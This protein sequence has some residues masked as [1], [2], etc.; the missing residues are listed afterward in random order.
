MAPKVKSLSN[1]F[2]ARDPVTCARELIGCGF[3]WRG[4][5]GLVVET[6]AYA[7][8]EDEACHT[9]FK[10]SAR[11]FVADHSVGD[12]YIYLNYGVHWLVNVLTKSQDHGDGFVSLRALQPKWEMTTMRERRARVR[13]TDLC[14]GPG[15]LS[16]ALGLDKTQ[17]GMPIASCFEQGEGEVPI[18]IAGPRIGISRAKKRPWRFVFADNPHVSV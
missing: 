16:Q 2:F 9:F 12:S 11:R 4:V 8:A 14:S 7:A 3:R 6:E 17:H 13:D 1:A 15:K 5:G 10:P 18:V